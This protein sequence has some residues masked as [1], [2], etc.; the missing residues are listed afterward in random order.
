VEL[1]GGAKINELLFEI[2]KKEMNKIDLSKKLSLSQLRFYECSF[3]HLSPSFI[4][5]LPP[6]PPFP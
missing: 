6:P 4:L 3:V 2:Y 5:L 1:S